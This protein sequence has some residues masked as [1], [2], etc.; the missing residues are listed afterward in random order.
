ME[1]DRNLRAVLFSMVSPHFGQIMFFQK[2]V[3]FFRNNVFLRK[4]APAAKLSHKQNKF[5][6]KIKRLR[7]SCPT[8]KIIL[9]LHHHVKSSQ[10]K[11][12]QVMSSHVKLSHVKLSHVK[13]SH[14]K[15]SH[16]KSS[17]VKLCQVKL[18]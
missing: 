18:S 2:Y 14:V 1:N 9:K 10:V 8:N 13:L 12:C 4:K 11:S 5:S 15:L 6:R 7:P 17:Q 16:V 3:F